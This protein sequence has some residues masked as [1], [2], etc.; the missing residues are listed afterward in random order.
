MQSLSLIEEEDG[1]ITPGKH[2]GDGIALA[3]IFGV[4]D[5]PDR[6]VPPRLE[7]RAAHV[8]TRQKKQSVFHARLVQDVFPAPLARAAT[9]SAPSE[10][11][12]ACRRSRS[13]GTSRSP[14]GQRP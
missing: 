11:P 13:P 2:C 7:P 9:A 6:P 14:P 4:V 5:D 8:G 12:T 1:I 10:L 3:L